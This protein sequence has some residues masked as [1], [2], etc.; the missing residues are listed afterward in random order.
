MPSGATA[1][2]DSLGDERNTLI[3]KLNIKDY[4]DQMMWSYHQGLGRR[5]EKCAKP[6]MRGMAGKTLMPD[7]RG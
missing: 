2:E 6:V 3:L 5:L 7:Q 1:S 4:V